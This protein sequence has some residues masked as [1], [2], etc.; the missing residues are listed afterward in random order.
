[1]LKSHFRWHMLSAIAGITLWRFYFRLFPRQIRSPQ[2]VEF[3][4]P[5]LPYMTAPDPCGGQAR[6]GAS[7]RL[8]ARVT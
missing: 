3:L 6:R 2:V 1:V 4:R 7:K 5:L 8:I